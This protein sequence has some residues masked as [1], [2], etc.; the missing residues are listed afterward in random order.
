MWRGTLQKRS[1]RGVRGERA[2]EPAFLALTQPCQDLTAPV[3][4]CHG[5]VRT[6]QVAVFAVIWK[7][8]STRRSLAKKS[9]T[10]FFVLGAWL[11]PAVAASAGRSPDE[12]TGRRE[13]EEP[14]GSRRN[15]AVRFGRTRLDGRNLGSSRKWVRWALP[16]EGAPTGRRTQP[17]A[18]SPGFSCGKA[19][20]R[21]EGPQESWCSE[22]VEHTGCSRAPL[23]RELDPSGVGCLVTQGCH[24]GLESCGPSGL[25]FSLSPIEANPTELTTPPEPTS[26]MN[27]NLATL[28]RFRG[29]LAPIGCPP[30]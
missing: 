3:C 9:L 15:L 25:S 30:R 8:T 24:P 28:W 12:E 23:E 13:E 29:R 26:L 4:R 18:I 22:Q 1:R 16:L 17:R 11:R 6:S 10:P 14:R 7:R 20:K 2:G 5:C 27:R 19:D 21:P